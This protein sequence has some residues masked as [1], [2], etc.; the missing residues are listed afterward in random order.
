[1][2]DEFEVSMMLLSFVKE[3][4]WIMVMKVEILLVLASVVSV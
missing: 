3:R 4:M 2:V 1:M